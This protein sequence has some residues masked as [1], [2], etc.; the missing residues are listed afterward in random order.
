M[1]IAH[2]FRKGKNE[3][4]CQEKRKKMK[5]INKV[6][7]WFSGLAFKWQIAI[8]MAVMFLVMVGIIAVAQ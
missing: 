4:N 7:V 6:E 5:W 8:A 1:E 2:S 3:L